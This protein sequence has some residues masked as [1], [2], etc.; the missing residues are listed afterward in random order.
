LEILDD[1]RLVIAGQDQLLAGASLPIGVGVANV[2]RFAELDLKTAIDMA[3]RQPAE[4]LRAT[5][6]GLKPGDPADLV[7]FDLPNDLVGATSNG[8]GGNEGL[9]IRATIA[10]GQVVHGEISGGTP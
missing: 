10:A 9:T 5:A 8:G 1:G 6:G 7:L 4:L 3:T 2:M